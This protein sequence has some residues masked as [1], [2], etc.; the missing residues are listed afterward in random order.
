MIAVFRMGIKEL[1]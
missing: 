1:Q